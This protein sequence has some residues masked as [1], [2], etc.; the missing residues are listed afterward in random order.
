MVGGRDGTSAGTGT[1]L[2]GGGIIGGEK[3]NVLTLTNVVL[4]NNQVTVLGSANIGGGGIQWTGGDLNITNSTIGGSAAPGLYTDR[5]STNTGNLEAGSGGGVTFT[6][7]AP[8]H[9]AATGILTVSA[10]TF[11]RNTAASPSARGAGADLLIFD[12]KDV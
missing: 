6:P 10:S 9:T 4:A 11:S 12:T 7:S 1:A 8:Q 2:G 5:T 3:G